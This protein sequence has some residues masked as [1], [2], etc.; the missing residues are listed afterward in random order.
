[1]FT[2]SSDVRPGNRLR[3][4]GGAALAGVGLLLGVGVTS[5]AT[6]SPAQAA[7][8]SDYHHATIFSATAE[9]HTESCFWWSNSYAHHGSVRLWSGWYSGWSY[10]H[11]D[12]GLSFTYAARNYFIG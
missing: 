10:A 6:A 7:C 4:K 12:S 3:R 2:A 8:K 1:M 5:L 11:A 9:A